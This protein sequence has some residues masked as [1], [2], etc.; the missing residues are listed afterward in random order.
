MEKTPAF[1]ILGRAL[2]IKRNEK[3]DPVRRASVFHETVIDHVALKARAFKP[4]HDEYQH[5]QE[6]RQSGTVISRSAL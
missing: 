3:K 1:M 6:T 5:F 2:R 4:S